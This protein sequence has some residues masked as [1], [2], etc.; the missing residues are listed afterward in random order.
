M[1][2]TSVTAPRDAETASRR[3][4]DRLIVALDVPTLADA[5]ALVEP[6]A[7]VCRWVKVGLELFTATGPASVEQMRRLGFHVFLDLKLHDIPNTVAGAVRSAAESGAEMLTVHT[8]GGPAMMNAAQGAISNFP[9]GP[10]LLGVT[11]LTS[12]DATQ[13]GA[14]G[15]SELPGMEVA[16]LAKL[17]H[18]SGLRGLVCSAEE[19]ASVRQLLGA[20]V[21]LVT[22]G[23]RPAGAEVGDQ[24]RVATPAAALKAGADFLVIGRPI[25]QA[26]DPA[27]AA[28]AIL[29]E[30]ARALDI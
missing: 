22:P 7:G 26:A 28:A 5:T 16:R 30:M 14:I 18:A 20:D 27:A 11:V 2:H 15:V 9:D 8:L 17:A 13:L 24:K 23:I 29:E 4:V 21:V 25:T 12:M 1:V 6:L 3:P 10:L 19:V